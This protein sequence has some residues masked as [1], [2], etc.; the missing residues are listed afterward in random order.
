[1]YSNQIFWRQTSIAVYL[2]AATYFYNLLLCYLTTPLLLYCSST[3]PLYNSTYS[4]YFT[5][6]LLLLSS[7]MA[8]KKMQQAIHPSDGFC[9][10][11]FTPSNK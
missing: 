11:I 3:Q 7:T 6:S 9:D 1:M 10:A 5:Y 4:T 8:E 2:S